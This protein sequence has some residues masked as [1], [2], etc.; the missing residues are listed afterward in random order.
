MVKT[1]RRDGDRTEGIEFHVNQAGFQIAA[2]KISI[3]LFKGPKYI[4]V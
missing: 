4:Q 2:L 1:V 3:L